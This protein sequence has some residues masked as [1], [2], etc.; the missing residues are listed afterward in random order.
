MVGM[1]QA[2]QTCPLG[3]HPLLVSWFIDSFRNFIESQ[4]LGCKTGS[5]AELAS[6][7]PETSSLGESS[8]C[9]QY[10]ANKCTI[11]IPINMLETWVWFLLA[12]PGEEG[13]GGEL[14]ALSYK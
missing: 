4:D 12:C 13:F 2:C 14:G 5:F 11:E 6:C 7:P 9:Q 3:G 1:W 8:V 10:R